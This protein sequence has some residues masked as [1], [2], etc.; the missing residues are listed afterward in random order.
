MK[1]IKYKLQINLEKFLLESQL[2]TW[3]IILAGL[4]PLL[5]F[6]KNITASAMF[7]L[8]T[9]MSIETTPVII[10]VS[11][12]EEYDANLS[13]AIDGIDVCQI[14][15]EKGKDKGLH[16]A[17]S[18]D[19][20]KDASE[21]SFHG[22]FS[23]V[24]ETNIFGYSW[25]RRKRVQGNRKFKIVDIAP[26]TQHL[27][28]SS[29]PFGK[30]IR[31]FQK[32][33]VDFAQQFRIHDEDLL[34]LKLGE[35]IPASTIKAT[36]QRLG[37]DL[38]AEHINLLFETGQFYIDYADRF[39]QPRS[40]VSTPERLTNTDGGSGD[41]DH[42]KEVIK[43]LPSDVITV[44]ESS[45]ILYTEIGDGMSG[46]FYQP[47]GPPSCNKKEA[48]YWIHDHDL[49]SPL[50]LKNRDGSC[51]TYAEAMIWLL[52]QQ[53]L[54]INAENNYFYDDEDIN[55]VLVDRSAPSGSKLMLWF[56]W[57]KKDGFQFTLPFVWEEFE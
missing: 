1:R 16:N 45:A 18:F 39:Y 47:E 22:T 24:Y 52:A 56:P 10:Q 41:W 54:Y 15:L 37:F 23:R 43:E 12:D 6:I 26:M 46:L 14:R 27:R 50:L 57:Y 21:L 33:T 3:I 8:E 20:P 5:G 40:Y 7:I 11:D 13:L 55:I 38:P 29:R 49:V 31:D 48:Y 9:S 28:D 30:R 34:F 35:A 36:E 25:S 51:K 17:C 19:L 42:V 4:I 2:K 32:V 44:L 53:F